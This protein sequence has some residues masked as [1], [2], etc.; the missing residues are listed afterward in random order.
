MSSSLTSTSSQMD[1]S[2]RTKKAVTF[3][4]IPKVSEL[5]PATSSHSSSGLSAIPED[6][7]ENEAS[8][9][10]VVAKQIRRRIPPSPPYPIEPIPDEIREGR[11]C[12]FYASYIPYRR[13]ADIAREIYPG[14]D[15]LEL[16]L[17]LATDT[18]MLFVQGM[19]QVRF[20]VQCRIRRTVV[21]QWHKDNIKKI[22][23]EVGS[24]VCVAV[25]RIDNGA[26]L[27][28]ASNRMPTLT[29]AGVEYLEELSLSKPC[30]WEGYIFC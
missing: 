15:K 25:V 14:R 28:W 16:D 4:L 29:V 20:G 30:W 5:E 7:P 27:V 2:S 18:D 12:F 13:I 8:N 19:L 22:K 9:P 6:A 17:D 3:D 21:D 1:A 23:G 10:P 24:E 11:D 26:G